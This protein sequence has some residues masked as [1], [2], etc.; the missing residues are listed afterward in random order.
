MAR[1]KCLAPL[2]CIRTWDLQGWIIK[3]ASEYD[4][5][6]EAVDIDKDQSYS[7][8]LRMCRSEFRF[9]YLWISR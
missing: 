3:R 6:N 1:D 5:K 2:A 9:A 8:I 4:E 7:Q